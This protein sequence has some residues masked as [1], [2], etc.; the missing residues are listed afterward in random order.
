MRD[1]LPEHGQFFSDYTIEESLS[2]PPSKHQL[3]I[4]AQGGTGPCESLLN[5]G[6]TIAGSSLVQVITT[7]VSSHGQRP[8]L[9]KTL[10]FH[11]TLPFPP[12]LIFP[13]TFFFSVIFPKP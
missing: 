7:A 2:L 12:A 11:M 13:S 5:P 10:A 6:W 9:A 4:A 8:W 3:P 1:Y